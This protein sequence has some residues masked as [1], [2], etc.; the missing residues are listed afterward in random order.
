MA[1]GDLKTVVA[2]CG[3]DVND[4]IAVYV[5]SCNAVWRRTR[6]DAPNRPVL[7]PVG[8][9]QEVGHQAILRLQQIFPAVA[10]EIYRNQREGLKLG[11]ETE[12]G[13]A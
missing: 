8:A 5:A 2:A 1:V 12:I 3:D 11:V 13:N 10:V 7:K 4:P 6:A 9:L